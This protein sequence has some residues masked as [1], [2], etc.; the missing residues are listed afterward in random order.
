MYFPCFVVWIDKVCFVKV[1]HEN[2]ESEFP[3]LS[4]GVQTQK[5]T[6]S[7]VGWSFR[8]AFHKFT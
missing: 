1:H 2:E 3:Q 6:Y 8:C 5:D 7:E 4:N